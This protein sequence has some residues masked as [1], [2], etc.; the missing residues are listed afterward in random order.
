LEVVTEKED[1]TIGQAVRIGITAWFLP[2]LLF[3]IFLAITTIVDGLSSTGRV[4]VDDFQFLLFYLGLTTLFFSPAVVFGILG[5]L[6]GRYWRKSRLVTW[7]GAVTGVI[8]ASGVWTGM[9]L[10]PLPIA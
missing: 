9:G 3:S 8:I 2:I 7:I 10:L 4:R 1:F 5:A 6:A